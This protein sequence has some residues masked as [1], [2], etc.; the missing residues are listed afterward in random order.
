MRALSLL[1]VD[2]NTND[3]NEANLAAGGVRTGDG[4]AA[5]L[6]RI[7][8][9]S[10]CTIVRPADDG[11]NCLP[12]GEDFKDFDGISWTGSAANVYEDKQHVRDQI[13]L[14]GRAF[15]SGTPFFGSCWGLQVTT[16]ALGGK[17]ILNPR[18]R[19]IC[20]GRRILLTDEGRDHCMYDGKPTAFD[21][22]T[23]HKDEVS[24]MPSGARLLASNE[25]SNVQAVEIVDGNKHF[26]GVQYHPE[27]SLGD[28]ANIMSRYGTG[29][30]DDGLFASE[31]E[32]ADFQQ[33]LKDLHL[34]PSRKDLAFRFSADRTVLDFDLRTLEIRNWIDKIVRPRATAKTR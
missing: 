2:G 5:V 7:A 20:I 12:E 19:E 17:V 4:Y 27:F 32:A 14:A 11:L 8:P 28:I 22:V 26:W 34:D 33:A 9:D 23:V 10:T 18:G 6:K 25:M 29:L 21:A 30:I 31:P 13:E 15:E 16:E 3:V 1:V 24:E